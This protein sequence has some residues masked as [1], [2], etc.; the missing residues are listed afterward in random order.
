M[1]K[2]IHGYIYLKAEW[3]GGGP[4]MPPMRVENI[5][6]HA[7]VQ[8]CRKS[9]T[10]E[11]QEKMLLRELYIDVNDPRNEM[12]I[13]FLK[14]T[15]NEFLIKLLQEDAKNPLSSVQPFRHLLLKAR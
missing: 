7:G 8:K 12:I 11:E 5:F 10:P 4:E 6:K 1:N 13:K 15:R 14:E 2:D 9:Y 3:Q